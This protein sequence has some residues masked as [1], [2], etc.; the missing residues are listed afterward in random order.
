MEQKHIDEM[1]D[2]SFLGEELVEDEE[3]PV[4][5]VEPKKEK[6]PAMAAAVKPKPAP[7]VPPKKKEEEIYIKPAKLDTSKE[8]KITPVV[9]SPSSDP[10]KKNAPVYKDEPKKSTSGWAWIAAILAIVLI[11][12]IFTGGF[13]YGTKTT[14]SGEL[15]LEEAEQKAL[16][17]VNTNL[18]PAPLTAEITAKED[19]GDLY[20][21][22]LSVAGEE[23][24]SYVTKDGRLFFARGFDLNNVTVAE[25]PEA[26]VKEPVKEETK[27]P[28]ETKTNETKPEV[29]PAANTTPIEVKP[30]ET[31]VEVKPVPVTPPQP[32]NTAYTLKA[33]KWMFDPNTITVTKGSKITFTIKPTDL[34]FTFAV[35][36]FQVEKKVAGETVVDFTA[37]KAGSYKFLCSD[38]EA[39][40]GMEGTLIVK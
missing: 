28:I 10:D 31:P 16:D 1:E 13:G 12:A 2:D 32:V 24:E 30:A 36:D 25:T 22:T 11:A 7:F 14:I 29:A 37:D 38:C 19:A 15:S 17:Y 33:K 3:Y 6:K 23:V 27:I 18:L 8:I 35:P 39:F 21:L 4:L 34:D 40:R 20:K 26:E 5:K 9:S